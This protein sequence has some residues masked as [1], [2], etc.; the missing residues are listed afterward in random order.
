MPPKQSRDEL[1]N[2]YMMYKLHCKSE[3]AEIKEAIKENDD[4]SYARHKAAMEAVD[5]IKKRMF[6][7]NGEEPI[8]KQISTNNM[9]LKTLEGRWKW[10]IGFVTA[11]S[12]GLIGKLAYDILT[13]VLKT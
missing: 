7:G 2:T 5:F 13:H 6:I 4:R 1:E 10:A 11:A 3:F 9:R 12:V 8:D